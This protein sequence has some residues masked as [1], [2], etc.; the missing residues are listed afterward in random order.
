MKKII[1]ILL[2]AITLLV[3]LINLNHKYDSKETEKINKE[4]IKNDNTES[5]EERL[6]EN[7]SI[8]IPIIKNI[9]DI[10]ECITNSFYNNIINYF[11]EN[12]YEEI[13][14]DSFSYYKNASNLIK[15]TINE[16]NIEKNENK[17]NEGVSYYD[18]NRYTTLNDLKKIINNQNI[19]VYYGE[20]ATNIAVLNYHFFYDKN[21]EKCNESICLDIKDFEKQLK[22]LKDNNFK[23]LTIEEYQS[24]IYKEID[25]PKKSVLLTID[26]GAMG[27]STINGNKLIPLLEKYEINATLFLITGWWDSKNYQSNYLDIQSHTHLMHDENKCS[28]KTRGAEL[29]CSN[30]EDI[31][32]DLNKSLKEVDNNLSFCF[33]F[34][35]YDDKS[36]EV[37]KEL[38]FKI[39]FI[40]GNKKSNQNIDK[41]KLP[42]YIIYKNTSIE[43]FKKMVN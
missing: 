13:I 8:N 15:L 39:A 43:S 27:T 16:E 5:K 17:E 9:C 37:L 28:N 7:I 6:K 31:I 21:T 34:Y 35:L 42:R 22:Y 26:D 18:F 40:G 12:N 41:Y 36:I 29:L 3:S 4:I 32:N 20:K 24:W 30:K 23:T 33:P 14:K 1:F 25:L 38:D 10:D 19:N 2:C 11:K